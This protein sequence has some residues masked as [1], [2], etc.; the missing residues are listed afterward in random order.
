MQHKRSRTGPSIPVPRLY[1]PSRSTQRCGRSVGI[2]EGQHWTEYGGHQKTR[3]R[4]RVYPFASSEFSIKI[5]GNLWVLLSLVRLI[6]QT[7]T[8]NCI[9]PRTSNSRFL[10]SRYTDFN[11]LTAQLSVCDTSAPQDNLLFNMSIKST[12]KKDIVE[13]LKAFQ[14]LSLLPSNEESDKA[15]VSSWTFM[16]RYPLPYYVYSAL[17][18]CVPPVT[19]PR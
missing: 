1:R 14:G 5:D 15:E 3:H 4:Q 8:S 9:Y 13:A 7:T 18:R 19:S 16:V 6:D 17:P 10:Q 12:D 2:D 11:S